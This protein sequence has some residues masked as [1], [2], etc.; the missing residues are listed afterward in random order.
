[1]THTRKDRKI[2]SCTAS[3]PSWYVPPP[4]YLCSPSGVLHF[5][6]DVSA[7]NKLSGDE[8]LHTP[9][10]HNLVGMHHGKRPCE[11]HT[12]IGLWTRG[13]NSSRVKAPAKLSSSLAVHMRV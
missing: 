5:V 1:M 7:L 12:L 11:H 10:M 4:W 13:S 6:A 8:G 2:P 9:D 3:R